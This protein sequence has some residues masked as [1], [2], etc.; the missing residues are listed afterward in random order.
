MLS[1]KIV[2]QYRFTDRDDSEMSFIH[3][4]LISL[5]DTIRRTGSLNAASEEMGYSYRHLWNEVNRWE[6]RFGKKLLERKRGQ[7]CALTPFAEKLLWAEK[8]VQAKYALEIQQLRSSIEQA[9]AKVLSDVDSDI[10]VSGCPDEALLLMRNALTERQLFLD[11][12]FNS[13]QKGLEDLRDGKVALAGFNFPLGAVRGSAAERTFGPLIRASGISLLRFCERIQGLAAAPGNPMNL[14]SLLDVSLK[15]ARFVN[16][17][18]GTGTRILCD[19]LLQSSGLQPQDLSGYDTVAPSHSQVAVMIASGKADAG[20]CLG[21]IAKQQG[22]S[23]IPLVKEVYLLA[24]KP[25]FLQSEAGE[26]LTDFLQSD[27]WKMKTASLPGYEFRHCGEAVTPEA[28]H[29]E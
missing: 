15:H 23:F 1:K 9:F 7:S 16:R 24:A 18:P 26:K 17:A 6:E 21:S 3:N 19:E 13:S 28:L 27:E 4:E 2:L 8:E 12:G 14:C 10:R 20:L 29:W 5:L 22:L 11:V 25:E